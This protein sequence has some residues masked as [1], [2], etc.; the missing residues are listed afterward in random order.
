MK[1]IIAGSR[2]FTGDIKLVGKI[3]EASGFKITE[4]ISGT[5]K[6]A[7]QAGD[8]WATVN[9]IP[10]KLFFA[11]WDTFGRSAGPRRNQEM[12]DYADALIAIKT[13]PDSRGTNDMI[14]RAEA[15]GLKI[16]IYKTYV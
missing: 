10:V 13:H 15:K 8:V 7:D 3:V 12:A 16:F 5:A 1:V 4:V 14:R 9:G 2:D 11:N 6:G